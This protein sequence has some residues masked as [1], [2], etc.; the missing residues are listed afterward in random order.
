MM[1]P[2]CCWRKLFWFLLATVILG[3]FGFCDETSDKK[4]K[5]EGFR[6]RFVG[7]KVGNR[8]AAIAGVP[9]DANTY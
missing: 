4:E 3:R 9:G 7:P 1:L 6:F 2:I 8:I 5:E